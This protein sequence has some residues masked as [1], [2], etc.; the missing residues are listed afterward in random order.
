MTSIIH[1]QTPATPADPFVKNPPDAATAQAKA[2]WQNCFIVFESYALDKN[3]ALSVI[4]GERG[5]ADAGPAYREVAE[6]DR[7][8]RGEPDDH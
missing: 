5:G 8:G 6:A 7:G 4:E 3:D 2:G 1:A